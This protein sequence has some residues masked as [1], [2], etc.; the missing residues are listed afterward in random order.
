MSNGGYCENCGK[1]NDSQIQYDP[2]VTEIY[3]DEF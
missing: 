3:G 1:T 2:K